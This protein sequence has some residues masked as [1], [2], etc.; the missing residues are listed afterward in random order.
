MTQEAYSPPADDGSAEPCTAGAWREQVWNALLHARQCSYP[1]PPH[2]HHPNF[3]GARKAAAHLLAHPEVAP[4]RTLVVGPERALYPLRQLALRAGI[5]LYVPH[6]HKAGWYWRVTEPAGARLSALNVHGELAR[7]PEGAQAAVLG[8]VAVDASG[9]RL[10][11]GYG[12][13]ARG[14][15]LGVPEYTLAHPLMLA[16]ALPCPPDSRVALIAL[17]EGVRAAGGG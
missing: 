3:R 9:G 17:P 1:L 12:W 13:G 6:P 16:A 14:L 8:S 15:G 5:T 2:G 4:L 10:G 7:Q 11:K